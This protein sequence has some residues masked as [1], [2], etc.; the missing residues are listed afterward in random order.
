MK[1]LLILLSMCLT[2]P[3][4]AETPGDYETLAGRK[5]MASVPGFSDSIYG[6]SHSQSSDVGAAAT[7]LQ[8]CQRKLAQLSEI[9]T[10]PPRTCE[11]VN[12]NEELITTGASIR[13]RIPD[14]PHPLY[15]WRYSSATATV[16]LAGS[17]H[18]LK[19]TI[20]PLAP[21]L[22]KAFEL[23]DLLVLEVDTEKYSLTEMQRRMMNVALLQ[24]GQTLK[25][26]LDPALMHNLNESLASYGINAQQVA[27]FKP[28]MVMNQ[29][30]VLRLMTLG[31]LPEYGLE[32]HF[33]AKLANRQ[34][35]ELESIDMQLDVLFNQ[36]LDLQI[37]LLADTLELEHEIEPVLAEMVGAWLAGNDAN[38]LALIAQ[39][40][41]TSELALAFSKRILDDRNITMA[42][43]IGQYLDTVGTY[44]VLA[45]VAH[46]IGESSIVSLLEQQ[47]ITGKRVMSDE[48]I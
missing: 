1:R 30:V 19:A 42:K 3:L 12:L 28:A 35:L 13:A 39:Q 29:L 47:G 34:I 44:F 33:R 16:Y 15:L 38:L 21:Q 7:A 26:V 22:E 41:G 27:Q 8:E 43:T 48:Q 5:A 11:V 31:Y 36:P 4:I 9:E 46:F 40:S 2:N 45:G 14:K 32:Q 20:Y 37:Q 17:I 23:S 6:I 10:T 25:K 24:E 18:I